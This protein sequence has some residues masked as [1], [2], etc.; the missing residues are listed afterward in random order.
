MKN[1][2][3]KSVALNVK[4]KPTKLKAEGSGHLRGKVKYVE[5]DSDS[6]ESDNDLSSDEDSNDYSTDEDFKELVALLV[7]CFKKMGF[8]RSSKSLN[9]SNIDKNNKR[10]TECESWSENKIDVQGQM[11]Q[12]LWDEAICY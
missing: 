8:K 12:L 4:V 10:K 11:L 2:K 7:K 9:F 1:N 6:S 3:A 5:S